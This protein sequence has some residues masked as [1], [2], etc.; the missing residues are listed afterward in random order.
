MKNVI[1]I[2]S[3]LNTLENVGM[4]NLCVGEAG[5]IYL[6]LHLKLDLVKNNIGETD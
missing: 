4:A 3:Q 6:S 5:Q 1:T 2:V